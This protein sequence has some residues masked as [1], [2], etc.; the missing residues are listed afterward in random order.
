MKILKLDNQIYDVSEPKK[1]KPLHHLSFGDI[2]T[3]GYR[4]FKWHGKQ[5]GTKGYWIPKEIK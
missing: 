1:I 4:I 3:N 5:F 2:I